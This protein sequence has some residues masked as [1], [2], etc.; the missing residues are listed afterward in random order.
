MIALKSGWMDEELEIFSDSVRKF[1]EREAVPHNER[2]SKA[3][4]IDRSFW[5]KAGDAGLLCV[6]IP[7]EYGGAG[8]GFRHEAVITQ[9][10]QWTHFSG[11]GNGVHSGICAPYILGYGTEEQKK[12]WL[13]KMATGELVCAI[14]MTEPGTG[15]D[16]QAVRTTAKRDGNSLVINGQKTF[17]TNGQHADL[18]IVVCKTGDAAG[19]AKNISLVMVEAD[20]PGFRRGRN[21]DK[22]GLHAADTSELFFDDVRV[23]AD[24]VLG[25]DEGRGFYQ[26]M[27]QLPRERLIIAV[28][29]VAGMEAAIDVTVDYVKQR[30]AFGKAL[31]DFQNTQ[32]VLADCKA[33]AVVA[34][35]FLDEY[36]ARLGR[37]ELTPEEGAIAKLWTCETQCRVVDKCLQLFGG[38]GYMMEYPIGRMYADARV[39]RIYGG[40]SEIMRLLIARA[41]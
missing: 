28:G 5:N 40:T 18:I 4:I 38:Y 16:L 33:E 22:V 2:W 9:Q 34:R 25:G 14:A 30:K 19:G 32:F 27:Q 21:L 11:W 17:I 7:E 10:E 26:L 12:R 36:I 39:Q 23:P 35:T 6:T 37:G 31:L 1:F 3:G 8:G 24:Y 29:A 13:P 20:S 41:L 15:S